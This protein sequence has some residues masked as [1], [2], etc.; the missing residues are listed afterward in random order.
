MKGQFK[1]QTECIW[2]RVLFIILIQ[3]ISFACVGCFGTSKT[4]FKN[5]TKTPGQKIDKTQ[6]ISIDDLLY[7]ESI[8]EKT[9]SPD[10]LNVAWIK[11]SYSPGSEAPSTN[12]FLTNLTDLSTKKLTKFEGESISRVQWAADSK[13][14]AF[15]SNIPGAGGRSLNQVWRLD[16]QNLALNQLTDS[17][18]GIIDFVWGSAGTILYTASYTGSQKESGKEDDTIRVTEYADT[19][20]CLFKK[21]IASG[22]IERI[23]SNDDVI[24]NLSASPDGRYIF[25]CRTKGKSLYYQDIPFQYFVYDLHTRME[26][27]V[28]MGM[29]AYQSASW[30]LNSKAL[31]ITEFFSKDKYMFGFMLTLRALDTT[32]G[33]EEVIDLNWKRGLLYGVTIKPTENGFITILEDGCHPKLT[34]YTKSDRGYERRVMKAEHQ[35]NI[36][37]LDLTSDGK[38]MCYEYSTSSIPV[39]Y[40]IASIE[41]DTVKNP[42]QFTALNPQFEGKLFARAE[43]ITWQGALGDEIE[44]MLYYPAN[45]D[46]SKKYPLII[47]LHGG[48][49]DCTRDRWTLLGWMFPY[50][51]LS[52]KGAFI[53]DPN[54]HGSIGYGIE[55]ARSIRDGKMYEYPIE[56]IEKGIENLLA[57]GLVDEN[58]LGTMGWSQGSILSHA[59]I[60][61][62]QR[63]KAASCGA[64][65]TEWVSYWGQSRV[66]HSLCD[67][68][69]GGSPLDKPDRYINEKLAPFY[70]AKKVKTPVIMFTCEKDVNV[71]SAMNI[72]AYRGIQ[73]YGSAPVELYIFP[74]EPHVLQKLSHHR[75]KMIEEQ[76]W[77]DKYLFR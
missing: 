58:K 4:L 57:L 24:V 46:P 56:D 5:P 18:D 15:M 35:G 3:F 69:L 21:E 49:A 10:G 59:L 44:G 41:G 65:G 11:G 29:K 67:Y 33:K 37:S 39:Q 13:A 36:F 73:K 27:Q 43:S 60:T 8:S 16:L 7:M 42:R 6:R 38:T 31:F 40:Y 22:Q 51:I 28:F 34:K 66:G 76:N 52:Q 17:P 47:Y 26:R 25:M 20:V 45:Y 14:I 74:G 70:A 54:Y 50:H 30:S 71:P 1:K 55:F 19:P 68:Y 9:I 64:G 12:I 48:P 32:T 61:Q 77:F 63:F 75:R 2:K 53:L 23:T 62:D 72:I